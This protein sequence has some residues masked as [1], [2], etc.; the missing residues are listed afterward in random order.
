M[1]TAEIEKAAKR[2]CQIRAD[3][4]DQQ[5][6]LQ[7]GDGR[8]ADVVTAKRLIDTMQWSEV[9]EHGKKRITEATH[10]VMGKVS[11]WSLARQHEFT[12]LWATVRDGRLLFVVAD[13]S[14]SYRE[15]IHDELIRLEIELANDPKSDPVKFDTLYV[16]AGSEEC[17]SA[18]LTPS[19]SAPHPAYEKS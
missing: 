12:G 3:Q 14:E 8:D 2:G 16:P 11:A 6:T 1:S 19:M 17:L 15:A 4:P 13:K 10:Y 5:F 7:W 9:E 18:F